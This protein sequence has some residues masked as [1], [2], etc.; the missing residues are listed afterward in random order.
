[1]SNPSLNEQEVKEL[2]KQ[3][4]NG[5][6][7]NFDQGA[8]HGLL[9]ED[10]HQAWVGVLNRLAGEEPLK[11]LD[12]GC[13]TG[14]LS[15]LLAKA[16]HEVTGVDFAD[17]MLQL[18]RAKA[19]EAGLQI[20]FRH[21]DAEQTGLPEGT[22][23]LIVA[24]HVIWTLPNPAKATEG[25]IRLLKPQGRLALVEGQWENQDVKAEYEQIRSKLPFYGGQPSEQLAAF[26]RSQGLHD[27]A[28]EPLMEAALWGGVP[29]HP[30]YL[31]IGRR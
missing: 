18:A 4:W 12:V 15:L 8:S 7:A 11:V 29:Q 14:F 20:D 10:Q 6:A 22:Y 27:V 16:G 1:M 9:N 23:D 17:E 31:I 3:H 5:R 25:W 26:F 28:I 30:R 2:V 24:R 13:G 21:G 19:E